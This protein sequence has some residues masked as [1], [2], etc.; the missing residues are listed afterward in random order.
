MRI[1]NKLSIVFSLIILAVS[2]LFIGCGTTNDPSDNT[3]T[4]VTQTVP[5]T[6]LYV[7]VATSTAGGN[8]SPRNIVAIWVTDSSG[9]F[10]KT[11]TVYADKRKSDLT[12]WVSA[13]N[14]NTTDA[15]TGATLTSFGT[16]TAKWNGT[17]TS[18][19][20]VADGSYNLCM[21]LTDKGGTGNYSK[22]EFTKG[23][24]ELSL[25]PANVSSFSSI[26]IKWMPLL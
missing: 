4:P 22:F 25:T 2:V 10:V 8:Y 21:E 13:S 9:K 18:G 23:A 7:S 12:N 17:N 6:G 24:T 20:V 3:S 15:V 5:S 1:K 14:K 26:S 11:L 19:T 16:I